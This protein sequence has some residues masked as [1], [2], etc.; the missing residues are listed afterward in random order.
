MIKFINKFK[1]IR[2]GKTSNELQIVSV[3]KGTKNIIFLEGG[4]GNGMSPNILGNTYYTLMKK[5]INKGYTINAVS[6]KSNLP[7]HYT[8]AQMAKDI[9][10][11]INLDFG[12]KVNAIIGLSMGGFLLQEITIQ[13]PSISEKYILLV[14]AYKVNNEA[15]EFDKK[16]AQLFSKG[17]YKEALLHIGNK[18]SSSK[19]KNIFFKIGVILFGNSTSKRMVKQ[20]SKT[21]SSDILVE[22]EAEIKFNFKKSLNKITVPILIIGVDKDFWFSPKLYKT[23]A[24]L[25]PQGKLIMLKGRGHIDV[26]DKKVNS[27]IRNYILS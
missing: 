3:G 7:E 14:S 9:I 12:G 17:K 23:T 6:R 26:M 20:T 11:M 8:I 15:C 2:F 1:N 22:V 18:L 10:E 25:I 4:P 27:I 5:L 19:I 24:K 13:K 21:Y 16:Y